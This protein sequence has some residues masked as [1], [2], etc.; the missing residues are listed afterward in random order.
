MHVLHPKKIINIIVTT[1]QVKIKVKGISHR[2][3]FT[4][5]DEELMAATPYLFWAMIHQEEVEFGVDASQLTI[6]Y[7]I[8]FMGGQ[9]DEN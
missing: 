7:M 8:R 2:L 9:S 3:I 4:S 1:K 5:Y 6:V